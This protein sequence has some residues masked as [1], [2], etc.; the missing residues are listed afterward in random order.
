MKKA[1]G[2]LLIITCFLFF[3]NSLIN[4]PDYLSWDWDYS[5]LFDRFSYIFLTPFFYLTLL[6]VGV[7][8]LIEK[9]ASQTNSSQSP[10]SQ[11]DSNPN[12]TP[13]TGLNIVSFLVP[14]VGLVIYL[15][16]KDKAPIKAKSAG[17]AAIWG[18]GV[19]VILSVISIIISFAMI[20]SIDY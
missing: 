16:E 12:D 9:N 8:M 2:V 6:L 15:T 14:I 19:S 17:K 13:S 1:V 4:I 5:P 7:T 3:I 10:A 20:S 18:V 11:V